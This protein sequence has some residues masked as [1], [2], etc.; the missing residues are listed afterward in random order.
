[1]FLSSVFGAMIANG[2][3]AHPYL[4]ADNRHYTFYIWKN[5]LGRSASMRVALSPLYAACVYEVGCRFSRCFGWIYS[6]GF[7][8]CV[9][10]T[11]LPAGLVEFRYFTVPVIL[12]AVHVQPPVWYVSLLQIVCFASVN[13]ATLYVL[14]ERP[15]L[16][17]DASVARFMW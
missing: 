15:F 5:V 16:W 4:L 6:A 1:M 14:T 13:A 17:P 3:I 12:F 10:A 9:A 8:V 11:L 7:W 2:T